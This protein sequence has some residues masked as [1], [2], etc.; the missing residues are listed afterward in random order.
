[1]GP[2]LPT[3]PRDMLGPCGMRFSSYFLSTP[4]PP[5]L[6]FTACPSRKKQYARPHCQR[7]RRAIPTPLAPWAAAFISRT[8]TAY[9]K[10]LGGA[11]VYPG[12]GGLSAC[13][14][15][16]AYWR[17]CVAWCWALSHRSLR[18]LLGMALVLLRRLI[19]EM[20]QIVAIMPRRWRRV[21][22]APGLSGL[23]PGAGIEKLAITPKPVDSLHRPSQTSLTKSLQELRSIRRRSASMA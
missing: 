23:Q 5:S 17:G 10:P 3:R 18:F 7:S 4:A 16:P 1:M 11:F 21:H 13:A 22:K 20:R 9:K 14:L 12:N 8:L 15:A 19:E 6:T 2:F